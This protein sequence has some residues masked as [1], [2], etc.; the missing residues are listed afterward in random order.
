[1]F[2][3]QRGGAIQRRIAET[4]REQVRRGHEV[5]VY[6]PGTE[7]ET[8]T[9]DGVTVHY[10]PCRT[11]YPVRHLEFVTRAMS[12]VRRGFDV[13]HGHSEPEL[14]M[15]ARAA[16]VPAVMQYDNYYFRGGPE[17]AI[18]PA[19]RR[20]WLSWDRLL[21]CSEYCAE[22]SSAAWRLPGD[23]VTVVPNGVNTEQ[24]SPAPGGE[25]ASRNGRPPTLLYVGRVCRQK[26]TDVL[27]DALPRI[28]ESVPDARLVI[29]GPIGQF[30]R[31]DFM[32]EESEES[33]R[34]RFEAAGVDYRGAVD[35]DDLVPLM[36]SADVFVMPTRELEMF[37]MA[38]VEAAA[39]GT[40]VVA[41]DHGGLRE[42]VPRDAGGRFR[43]EDPVDLADNVT[44]LLGPETDLAAVGRRAR[45][46][47]ERYAWPAVVDRLEEVY[48]EIVR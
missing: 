9:I 46:D 38:A 22:A 6:S 15:L 29:G 37:G 18:A 42:T 30:D 16:R 11:P 14:G 27:L 36:R 8:R 45:E 26:G 32:D 47:A 3:A 40:P 10:L 25:A 31:T 41:S 4:A 28:R 23:R 13:I 7:R 44:R 2:R 17:S 20:A 48:A 21:P 39:C 33:W 1:V 24:F 19:V 43:N 12:H 35:E 5:V 34:A